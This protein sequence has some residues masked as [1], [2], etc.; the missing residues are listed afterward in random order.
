[1]SYQLRMSDE[2]HAWLADLHS[3]D[4]PSA[5]SVGRALAA[6]MSAGAS[7]GPPLVTPAADFS[8]PEE[9][10]AALDSSYQDRLE[11]LT[12][13]RRRVAEAATLVRD[14]QDR[15]AELEAAQQAQSQEAAEVRRLLARVTAAERRLLARSQRLQAR[16]DAFRT[17]IEVLKATYTAARVELLMD[18]LTADPGTARDE[19]AARLRDITGQIERELRR[20]PWPEGLSEL[21]PEVPD[22]GEIRI[23]FAVEPAG[24]ALLI[25]VLE[26][27][28][29]VRD[30][31]REAV[32]RSAD[33]LREARAGRAPE[34][35]ACGYDDPRS[36]LEEFYPGQAAEVQAAA[37]ALVSRN[38]AR[39]LA[40]TLAEQRIRLGF[41]QAEVAQRMSV[42]QERVSAI[43]R[44]EPDSTEVRTLASYVE[45]LGGR[46]EIIADFSGD[47]VRLR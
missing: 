21:R 43:E 35:T 16:I 36:F 6:L 42:R 7:L 34:A 39:T 24:T 1:V 38:R 15:L 27:R 44:A 20:M 30:Q 17:R 12:A 23:I 31:Y 8:P 40:E 10:T 46:L 25:A 29:A 22:G 26:G 13:V 14:L 28:D 45:A 5:M 33:V 18:E 11:R 47:R 19:A 37:V 9:L 2:I 4:P 3:S 32:T 41:T